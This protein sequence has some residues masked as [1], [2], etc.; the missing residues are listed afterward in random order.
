M[1][2]TILDWLGKHEAMIVA[3]GSFVTA[4]VIAKI[5]TNLEL[6]KVLSIK[7]IEAFE[8]AKSYLT[9][10]LNVYENLL[11]YMEEVHKDKDSS[12]IETKISLLLVLFSRLHDISK[13]EDD[14]V[15]MAFYSSKLCRQRDA[16][17]VLRELPAF[18]QSFSNILMRSR[19]ITTE[20]EREN[21]GN[22]FGIAVAQM[23]LIIKSEAEHL[24]KMD[25]ALTEELRHDKR[26]KHLFR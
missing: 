5:T 23:I 15:R 11:L 14:L 4:I 6:R 17:V 8:S 12:T 26:L 1:L 21:L 25:N 13:K 7:R 24:C 19:T 20:K 2:N 18:L 10:M 9:S 16:A 22:D 3:L